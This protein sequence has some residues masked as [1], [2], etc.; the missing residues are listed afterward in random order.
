MVPTYVYDN[1]LP[2]VLWFL[3]PFALSR[4]AVF[5]CLFH[6]IVCTPLDIHQQLD[7]KRDK[8]ELQ[9]FTAGHDATVPV[10]IGRSRQTWEA[11]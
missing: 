9:I 3:L 10:T 5:V 2:S 4:V 1:F 7:T 8:S 11:L 6:I